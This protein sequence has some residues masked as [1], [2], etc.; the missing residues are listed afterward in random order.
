MIDNLAQYRHPLAK[1]TSQTLEQM[2]RK[3]GVIL[4]GGYQKYLSPHKG[5]SCAHRVLYGSESCSQYVKKML[6]E[7]DLQSAISLSRERFGRCKTAKIILRSETLEEKRRREKK[8]SSGDCGCSP[9][10]CI[11]NLLDECLPDC[12]DLN[13]GEADC[14]DMNCEPDCDCG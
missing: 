4:I 6:I 2:T 13:C 3:T 1:A 5:F 8:N 14:G 7:Q 12:N 10:G 11:N 9:E